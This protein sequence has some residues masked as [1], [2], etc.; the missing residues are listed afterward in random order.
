M[1]QTLDNRHGWQASSA[2]AGRRAVYPLAGA[3]GSLCQSPKSFPWVSLQIAT[4]PI[5][6]TGRGSF[7]SPPS[8]FTHAAPALMSSTS[9][10]ARAPACRAPYR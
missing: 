1:R 4:Q 10:Y 2:P 7:A 3:D 6:G 8:S 9:K 5:P